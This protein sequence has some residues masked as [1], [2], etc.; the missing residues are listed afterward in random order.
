MLSQDKRSRK[1]SFKEFFFSFFCFNKVDKEEE[2]VKISYVSNSKQVISKTSSDLKLV[3]KEEKVIILIGSTGKGKSTL[4]NVLVNR[5][6]NFEEIFEESAGSISK[7]REAKSERFIK[8]NLIYRVIDTVGLGDTKLP[9]NEVLDKI[10]EAVY[11]AKDGINQVF[12]VINGRFDV[13]EIDN[14][15]ILKSVIFDE[16]VINHTTI[17]RTRFEN[18]RDED[19]CKEDFEELRK[20]DS[21]REIID[22]CQGFVHVNN[23]SLNLIGSE[24]EG[25]D[26]KQRRLS[27]IAQRK[28]DRVFS[29]RR[30]IENLNSSE[31]SFYQPSKLKN[32]G[33]EIAEIIEK[34]KDLERVLQQEFGSSPSS[35]TLDE[36]KK[37]NT[38][39][40]LGKEQ[41]LAIFDGIIETIATTKENNK[42]NIYYNL[43]DDIK[44]LEKDKEKLESEIRI[45]QAIIRRK[46][47]RHILNNSE[48]IMENLNSDDFLLEITDDGKD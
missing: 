23:P 20:N 7:T 43:H 46:V 25:K 1:E 26:K 11:L 41:P 8:N 47:L 21:L 12:F 19:K 10:A 18:F 4:A 22:S 38:S 16:G 9:R 35:P 36:F 3:T 30:L 15:E 28:E 17:I 14:Y 42:E 6:N 13:K 5:N 45:K 2:H 40:S 31:E 29:R 48:A 32:L 39:F 44:K 27:R 34:K 33:S 24:D 37:V